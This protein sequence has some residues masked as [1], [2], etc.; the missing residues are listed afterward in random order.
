MNSTKKKSQD[1]S[2]DIMKHVV[3]LNEG[4]RYL[5]DALKNQAA[6]IK[7]HQALLTRVKERMGL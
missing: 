1:S 5:M 2:R 4:M 6:A 3:E 7:E